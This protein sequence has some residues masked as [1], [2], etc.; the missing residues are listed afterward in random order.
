[1]TLYILGQKNLRQHK[2]DSCLAVTE[3]TDGMT[4]DCKLH[5]EVEM[6]IMSGARGIFGHI[7]GNS[8]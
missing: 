6:Y 1:M 5:V 7:R 4:I 2:H 8:V 3:V